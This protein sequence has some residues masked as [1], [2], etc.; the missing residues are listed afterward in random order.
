MKVLVLDNDAG[1]RELLVLALGMQ[2]LQALPA[3]TVEEAEAFLPEAEAL[4]MDFHL[5]GGHSGAELARRWA[6]EG[7]LPRFWMVTGTPEDPE[8]HALSALPQFQ[9]VV[10]K[11]FRLLGLAQSVAEALALPSPE[12]SEPAAPPPAEP[13][14]AE[15]FPDPPLPTLE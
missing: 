1:M 9:A 12:S 4:L 10:G 11:P 14:D 7:R 2:Q 8:V 13:L 15:V 5:G 6:E 3:G